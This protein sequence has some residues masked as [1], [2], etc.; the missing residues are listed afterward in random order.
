[1]RREEDATWGKEGIRVLDAPGYRIEP[2]VEKEP[3]RKKKQQ[4]QQQET[5]QP[6][7][8]GKLRL[9]KNE[10]EMRKHIKSWEKC[11]SK[12]KAIQR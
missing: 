7:K 6:K 2:T 10:N 12:I 1:M 5:L 4:Q 8:E 11:Y 3:E 9:K